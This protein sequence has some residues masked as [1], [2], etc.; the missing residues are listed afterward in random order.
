MERDAFATD[1]FH[2]PM[3]RLRNL[4]F[5]LL[6][7]SGLPWLIRETLQRNRITIVMF[8]DIEAGHAAR[9]LPFLAR[10]Y[11]V[12]GLD[13]YLEALRSGDRSRIP[14]KALIITLDDGHAGNHALLPLLKRQ[15]IP[16]TIFLCSGL[17]DTRRQFWFQFE[18]PRFSTETLKKMPNRERLQHLAACGFTPD[19]EFEHPRAL[20]REQLCE[21]AA[22]VNLQAHT[23]FHPCLPTCDDAEA[24]A[25][26]AGSRLALE[27]EFGLHINAFAFPNGDYSDR[28]IA[29]VRDAGYQCAITV[30]HGFNTLHSDP[31]RLRRLGIDDADS[32]DAVCVKASGLWT[33]LRH[34]IG[35]ERL[36]GHMAAIG[37]RTS[38]GQDMQGA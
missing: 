31:F 13:D 9:V 22:V 37:E 33:L 27:Q 36:S 25:E 35:S 34:W 6:R 30:D 11:N 7:Y 23:R 38:T 21:M 12:I 24:E 19:R 5:T 8:H 4:A 16:V 10:S 17:L 28:D 15:R 32:I 20:N 14:R 26:I 1:P 29:L 2:Q 3:K 18:H